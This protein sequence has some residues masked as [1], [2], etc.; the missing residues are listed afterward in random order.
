MRV[1]GRAE[2]IGRRLNSTL[3]VIQYILGKDL[4][5]RVLNI[6]ET[7][8]QERHNIKRRFISSS[9]TSSRATPFTAF[10]FCRRGL[11]D[12]SCWIGSLFSPSASLH[13]FAPK[14]DPG[15]GQSWGAADNWG[16]GREVSVEVTGSG[17]ADRGGSS[18]L[19]VPIR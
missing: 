2:E 15:R 12:S 1:A 4:I 18:S 13:P 7:R 8:K 17:V 10:D 9:L 3:D 16:A 5:A 14:I 6:E 19:L 11:T